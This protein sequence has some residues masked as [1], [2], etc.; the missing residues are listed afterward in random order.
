M[1]DEPFSRRMTRERDATILRSLTTCFAEHGCFETKLDLV[2]D[3]VGIGKGT[4]YRH[5]G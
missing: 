4:L 1:T 3:E 2:A 5:Y